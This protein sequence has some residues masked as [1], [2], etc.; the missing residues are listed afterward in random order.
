[1]TSEIR[2]VYAQITPN[3]VAQGFYKLKGDVVEM[4]WFPDGAPVLRDDLDET[5]V[6][7]AKVTPGIEPDAV[8]RILTKKIRSARRGESIEGF[9][10]V[11][12]Y[13]RESF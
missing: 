9:N 3:E 7:T 12:V 5:S 6:F 1:V 10:R 11:I 13:P 4:V 2:Q 8:A